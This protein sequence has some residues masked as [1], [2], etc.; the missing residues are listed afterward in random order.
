MLLLVT[1]ARSP[2]L[3]LTVSDWPTVSLSWC[4]RCLWI[5]SVCLLFW[6]ASSS[7]LRSGVA[8]LVICCCIREL[9][10]CWCLWVAGSC[11]TVGISRVWYQ[12]MSW[13]TNPTPWTASF[14]PWAAT[15]GN[16]TAATAHPDP[17]PLGTAESAHKE[18]ARPKSHLEKKEN[19]T[20]RQGWRLTDTVWLLQ[21]GVCYK[22]LWNCSYGTVV[23]C[24]FWV[25]LYM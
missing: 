11:G 18:Q 20:I 19:G 21:C 24:T 4:L 13:H 7:R 5:F 12:G 10:W 23:H 16:P 6:S 17:W 22:K 2:C 14:A 25:F 15:S 9:C 3:H 8:T 1:E